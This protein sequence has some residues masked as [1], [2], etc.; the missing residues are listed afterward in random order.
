MTEQT[1]PTLLPTSIKGVFQRI[2]V[3]IVGIVAVAVF[4]LWPVLSNSPVDYADIENHFKYGS[5]GSEPI[6]G[7]PYWIWKV[8]PELFPDKLP[9]Q[10]YN[11]LGF[12]KEADKDLPVGFSQRRVF[13]DR[14]GLNCAVCHTGT[15]RN[16]P[17]SEHQVMT[18]MPAN[19]LNLQGYIKFLSAV[20]VDERFTA[21][22]MLPEIEKISGGLN[23]IEKLLYRFIAI[24]QT[25]DALIN[26]AY[27][28]KFVEE[29]PDWGPGRVDTFNPYKAIQFHFPMDKL[30]ED[31]LIGTSDF[32]SI[33][34]Q[35][36]REGLQLHW[37]GNNTSVDERNKSAALGTG[38]TP[39]TIDLPRI[40]RVA[41]WLWELPPP[42]YP[43][44]VNE[45]LA[46]T[47][48]PLFESNCASCHAFGGTDIGKVVPIQEIGTDP[49]RLDSFTYETI[50]NQNTLY[51][52]YPWRFKSFRKTNGYANMPLDGVWLRG[53]YLHNGSVPTLRD[54]LEKPENRP[55]EFYRGYDVIDR[56]KV[57]FV[58]DVAEENGKNYFK[59]DTKLDGNSNSGH[60]YGVDLSPEE[61]DAIVE[62]MKKL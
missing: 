34:N 4:F 40:Q 38:V 49:H 45:T 6:N 51:A 8:L 36:P 42:K 43:Y 21:N 48:K 25:R 30:R 61:K 17:N 9:G 62:Y 26:Q 44:E 3:V 55:Q 33:W 11:S 10:G 32:P 22:R 20:G 53:P 16:T 57:G 47:G 1:N 41:D 39:T 7:I 14:V 13:I 37:D 29:Q 52:G 60:L 54:L 15:L 27:R 58:S 24:P 50:S 23:P 2:W 31:E 19:V 35:K 28:L 12:I 5:I 56:E 46:V 18:T 59:F